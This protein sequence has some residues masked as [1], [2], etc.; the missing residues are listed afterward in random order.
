MALTRDEL[1]AYL[2]GDDDLPRRIGWDEHQAWLEDNWRAGMHVSIFAPNDGGKTHLIRH[3]LMPCWQLYPA[4]IVQYKK[5][6]P[7]LAGFGRAVKN[8]PSW[9]DRLPYDLRSLES[10]KWQSDP[11]WFRLV[12]PVYRWSSHDARRQPSYMRARRVAGEAIDR[13]YAEGGWVLVVDEVRRIADPEPPG[14]GLRAP[15]E[16]IWQAGRSEPVTLI[17]ATQQPASAPSSM[18]DQ[19]AIVYLGRTLDVGRHERLAEIGG[20][21]PLIKRTLPTLDNYEFL[22][23]HRQSGEMAIVMAPERHQTTGAEPYSRRSA[24]AGS[25][26]RRPR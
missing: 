2:D 15:L 25:P 22:F 5:R 17:G 16:N 12:L 14:L 24:L 1:A 3:G 21:T 13:V 23:V 11:E 20:N 8:F 18:Y 4:L 7:A 6:D 26:E 19:P 9:D 10:E